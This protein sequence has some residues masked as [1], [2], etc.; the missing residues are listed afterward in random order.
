MVGTG[1]GGFRS[2]RGDTNEERLRKMVAD[3]LR[4]SELFAINTR[5]PE[6]LASL[7]TILGQA[8]QA[9]LL[10]GKHKEMRRQGR[11]QKPRQQRRIEREMREQQQEL[12]H[13]ELS[14]RKGGRMRGMPSE[15]RSST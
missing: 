5:T 12:S 13:L 15:R 3:H 10:L 1:G 6:G 14:R 2:R 7:T 9:G 11:L 8:L 4:A